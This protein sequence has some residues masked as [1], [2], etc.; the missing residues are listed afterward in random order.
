MAILTKACSM[1]DGVVTFTFGTMCRHGELYWSGGE[2]CSECNHTI[3]FNGRSAPS[4]LR[5][6]E[7]EQDGLFGLKCAKGVKLALFY[8]IIRKYFGLSINDIRKQ[9]PNNRILYQGT[10]AEVDLIKHHSVTEGLVCEVVK[11]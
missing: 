1:C 6:I 7:I 3:E 5:Q 10:K 11:L 8:Q 4:D 2:I 9:A